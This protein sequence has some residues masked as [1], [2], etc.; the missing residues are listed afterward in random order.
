MGFR[1]GGAALLGGV[2]IMAEAPAAA[3]IAYDAAPVEL[4]YRGYDANVFA[5]APVPGATDVNASMVFAGQ[6]SNM[7]SN[8]WYTALGYMGDAAGPTAEVGLP[9]MGSVVASG[10]DI[11]AAPEPIV[12]IAGDAAG[13]PARLALQV[14]AGN[15]LTPRGTRRLATYDQVT[16][17]A[18]TRVAGA[19]D[20]DVA[21]GGVGVSLFRGQATSPAW[22][23]EASARSL[24]HLPAAGAQ[25]DRLVVGGYSGVDIRAVSDGHALWSWTGTGALKM[26]VG[27]I[28]GSTSAAF[29]VL[30]ADRSVMAFDT[31]TPALRWRKLDVAASD[32]ALADRDGDG[33]MEVLVAATDGHGF[34]LDGN[35]A[36]VGGQVALPYLEARVAVAKTDAARARVLVLGSSREGGGIDVRS[37]DLATS[38]STVDSQGAPFDR[39]LI[40]DADGDG[41]DEL[42]SLADIPGP[43]AASGPSGRISV[44]DL[45]THALRW[46]SA[47]PD[48]LP[49]GAS[50]P[51]IDVAIGHVQPGAGRQIVVLGRDAVS[52]AYVLEIVDGA[53]HALL[54]R[55]VLPL[56]DRAATRMLLTDL[57][58]DGIDEIVLAS[59]PAGGSEGGTKVHVLRADTLAVVWTSPM[60]TP[61][62]G[63]SGM[64]LRPVAGGPPHLVL[65]VPG[66]GLR[67]IDLVNHVVDYAAPIRAKSCALLPNGR[68]AV[69]DIDTPAIVVLDAN[70]GSELDRVA[71]PNVAYNAI[72]AVPGDADRVVVALGDH[73]QTWNLAEHQPEGRSPVVGPDLAARG[74]LLARIG[75][76]GMTF[77]A[78]NSIG[79]WAFPTRPYEALIFNDG[80]DAPAP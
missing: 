7:S 28:A 46:R 69:L 49:G 56:G 18:L 3:G 8:G 51:L 13:G 43:E 52:P 79:I 23:V 30:G 42:V 24:A 2:M 37:L 70:D 20:F 25:P 40:G 57:D 58:G 34:W 19:N 73:L 33:V 77:H 32:I 21:V 6:A 59:D 54:R 48:G 74:T 61:D 14:F 75:P 72:A 12:V 29:V 67:S 39:V 50:D 60:L 10:I 38:V 5:F 4:P 31:D 62:W 15:P 16:A 55:P 80:F 22:H 71:M 44:R 66:G 47:L 53:T 65:S 45:S 63:A 76:D 35:G 1:R 41:Q 36:Q 27:H 9:V 78:G 68:I 64:I 11:A 26:L 17:V